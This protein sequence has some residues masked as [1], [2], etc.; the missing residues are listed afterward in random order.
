M[1]PILV[2]GGTGT[3]GRLVVPRLR[4]AGYHVRVLSRRSRDGGKGVEFVTG[5]LATGE[6]I[7][8]AVEGTEIIVHCAGSTKGDEDKARHLVRAASRA[9][10]RHLVYISVV[11]ADRIPVV[12]GIDRAMFGYFA[13]KL[14]AEKVIADSGLPW[15]T[16][17]AT[18]FHD[19]TLLTV[20]QLARLPVIPV[21]AGWR[22]Q[23]VDPGE[24]AA[25]LVELALGR[26]AGLV[27]DIAGPRVYEL[28]DL[29]RGYLGA[30]GKHRPIL[31][32]RLPGRAARAFRAG[33]NL[34]PDRAVGRR[35]WE[36]FLADELGPSR[37]RA[38]ATTRSEGR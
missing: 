35:T 26:P 7:D 11:G 23:P 9:G 16:L 6:G 37:R 38:T 17:R 22:F 20:R 25:R 13:A 5:D 36:D 1:Q 27:P 14:A 31:P 32:V 10:A 2:T 33:A 8:A 28:A 12:S 24:V 21:P 19:L 30:R 29:V 3:L 4:D 18:Q 34:A 15:T